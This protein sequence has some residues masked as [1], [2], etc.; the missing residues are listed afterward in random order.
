MFH[1]KCAVA[2]LAEIKYAGAK[3]LLRKWSHVKEIVTILQIPYKATIA[4]QKQDLTLS[5]AFAIWLKIRIHLHS[6]MI[7]RLCETKLGNCLINALNNRQQTIYKNPAML[8]AIY[9]DPRYRSEIILDENLVREAIGM[10]SNL[11]RRLSCFGT[12]KTTETTTDCSKESSGLNTSIDFD[13]IEILDNYLS[14]SCHAHNSEPAANTQTLSIEEQLELFQPEKVSSDTSIIS[15]WESEKEQNNNLYQLAM[16]IYAIPPS[17]T[18]IERDF[19][20]LEFIF[21][22]KRQRLSAEMLESILTIHLNSDIFFAIRNGKLT[23]ILE[24]NI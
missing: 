6:P 18:Q 2:Y 19:S 4:L 5:D 8:S 20:T 16:V 12:E 7:I 10:L 11:W 1:C 23:K 22:Q 3:L 14:R 13:N 17:E 24:E 9:L 15:F 21:S